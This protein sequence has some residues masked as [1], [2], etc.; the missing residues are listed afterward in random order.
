M[1]KWTFHQIYDSGYR[2]KPTWHVGFAVLYNSDKT[3]TSCGLKIH[4]IMCQI[5]GMLIEAL[6]QHLK[7]KKKFGLAGKAQQRLVGMAAK[8]SCHLV[9]SA[10]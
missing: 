8:V 10:G 2:S 4:F 5:P 7:Y 1:Y 6:L 9:L 3:K